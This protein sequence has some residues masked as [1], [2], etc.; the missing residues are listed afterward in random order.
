MI[1]AVHT[2]IYSDDPAATRAFLRDVVGLAWVQ[3][4]S[5]GEDWPIF[6]T[7][8]SELGVH[9]T[10]GPEFSTSRHHEISFM[11]IDVEAAR[12]ELAA[13]GAVFTTEIQD[14]GWGRTTMMQV[15]GADDVMVYQ[16]RYRPAVGEGAW[17]G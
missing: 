6:T 11:V 17:A 5:E 7:G 10:G 13:R 9:P 3:T 12:A 14:Q 2:L 8:P 15:P 1:A 4:A 16:P